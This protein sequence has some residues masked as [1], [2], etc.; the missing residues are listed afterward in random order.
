MG[1]TPLGLVI[2]KRFE[3]KHAAPLVKSIR[4]A[5]KNSLDEEHFFP[6]RNKWIASYHFT[7]SKRLR[8][9]SIATVQDVE[10]RNVTGFEAYRVKKKIAKAYEKF[11]APAPA[12]TINLVVLEIDRTV[13]LSAVS[14]ALYGTEHLLLR[15]GI[16]GIRP[17]RKP[18]GFF[19]RGHGSRLH[20]VVVIRRTRHWLFVPYEMLLFP[21][22]K[23][24]P[25][26]LERTREALGID[27]VLG[28]EQFP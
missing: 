22:P 7:R 24:L 23:V 5:L 13:H 11:P 1:S 12:T 3:P 8:H 25:P 14:D 10:L 6:A 28:A 20:G 2:T 16:E 18:D 21:S 15:R 9:A 19:S 4:T 17:A 27:R 26:I